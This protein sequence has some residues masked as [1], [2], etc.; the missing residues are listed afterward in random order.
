MPADD[1]RDLEG[2]HAVV[3]GSALCMG[4]LRGT[5]RHFARRHGRALEGL[6]VWLFTSG[7]VDVGTKHREAS[8]PKA[9]VALAGR[10]GARAHHVRRPAAARTA[11]PHGARD[12]HQHAAR[13]ARCARRDAI[14]AWGRSVAAALPPTT[15]VAS[16]RR[17]RERLR[18][19]RPRSHPTTSWRRPPEK[20]SPRVPRTSSSPSTAAAP[21]RASSRASTSRRSSPA[22]RRTRRGQTSYAVFVEMAKLLAARRG[23]SCVSRACS[24]LPSP[25][26]ELFANGGLLRRRPTPPAGPSRSP[27]PSRRPCR[28]HGSTPTSPVAPRGRRRAV[29]A[30][31]PASREVFRARSVIC[32]VRTRRRAPAGT[33]TASAATRG[34]D[35]DGRADEPRAGFRNRD[36]AVRRPPRKV[37]AAVPDR[38][39]A[40]R[41]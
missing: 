9:A 27:T 23:D 18:P 5:G 28:G 25:D 33:A 6:P 15:T 22:T 8:E 14:D 30:R 36:E 4:R 16:A 37:R 20:W 41:A 2:W 7:P 31:S 24:T 35:D 38:L 10:L 40:P 13:A 11:Q 39:P 3:L 32:A 1:V 21:C 29:A 17:A 19:P 34:G 26:R 12:G